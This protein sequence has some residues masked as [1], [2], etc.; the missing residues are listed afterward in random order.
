MT[1]SSSSPV[2]SEQNSAGWGGYAGYN[3]QSGK[4]LFG[5]EV[6]ASPTQRTFDAGCDV[7]GIACRLEVNGVY[8]VEARFGWVIQ[9]VLVYGSGGVALAPWDASVVDLATAQKL[10]RIT[11]VNYGVAVAAGV[12]YKPMQNLG[13]RAELAHY[14]MDGWAVTLPAAGRTAN[15]FQNYDARLGVT[16]YFH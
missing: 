9:N 3:W 15:Q 7:P 5:L 11:G 4:G 1:W 12:E 14:G 2:R 13:I 8:S 10:D 6:T 16:W